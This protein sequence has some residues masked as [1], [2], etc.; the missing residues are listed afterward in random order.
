MS[1]ETKAPNWGALNRFMGWDV[2]DPKPTETT[3]LPNTREEAIQ[4]VNKHYA[5]DLNDLNRW[6]AEALA[7]IEKD[8]PDSDAS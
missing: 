5:D 3:R 4:Q 8:Y 7:D 6:R 2:G 1:D